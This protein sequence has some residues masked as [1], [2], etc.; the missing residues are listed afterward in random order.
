MKATA[1]I[2]L[3]LFF[4]SFSCS[5][6]G[7]VSK[8]EQETNE[9]I[10]KAIGKTSDE[11][12]GKLD[13]LLTLEIA[14]K[15]AGYSADQ[16][17]KEYSKFLKDPATHSVSYLWDKGRIKK[18]N[19]PI[20]NKAM[21]VPIDDFV[22]I[23]WVRNTTLDK[24]KFDYHT[25]TVEEIEK[26]N[27]AMDAK[28]NEMVGEGKVTKDQADLSKGM[29]NGLMEGQSFIPVT[30]LGD[31]AMWNTKYKQLKVFYRGLEFEIT[32]EI[33]DSESLNKQKSIEVAQRIIKENL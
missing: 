5:N 11:F 21:N 1:I 4:L 6:T 25:P 24:F 22:K 8:L 18:V 32:V 9:A 19:N 15:V 16:A 33:S 31:H 3:H 2:I 20:T 14:S 10:E 26:A 7:G 13:Q 27:E 17:K 30:H 12:Y 29:A 23:S 28:L